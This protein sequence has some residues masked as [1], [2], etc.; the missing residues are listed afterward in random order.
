MAL[1]PRVHGGQVREGRG[2]R[3]IND[4]Y[5]DS[6]RESG[7][8]MT[9][10]NELTLSGQVPHITEETTIALIYYAPNSMRKGKV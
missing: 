6:D 8:E 5:G 4:D 9:A 7:E 2:K 10:T 3:T 1:I